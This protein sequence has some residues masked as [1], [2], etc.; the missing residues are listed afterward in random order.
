MLILIS[1][2]D[3]CHSQNVSHAGTFH[4]AFFNICITVDEISSS[5]KTMRSRNDAKSFAQIKQLT[6]KVDIISQNVE[7]LQSGMN[8]ME[9]KM[10]DMITK[11][12]ESSSGMSSKTEEKIMKILAQLQK[13]VKIMK[14]D[15]SYIKA[16]WED[17][18]SVPSDANY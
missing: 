5:A 2:F 1:L 6:E 15:I 10:S 12:I 16:C 11:N 3:S 8:G 18:E 9:R 17:A 13:D 7:T 14:N 4:V